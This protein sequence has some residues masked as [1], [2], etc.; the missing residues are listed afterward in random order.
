VAPFGAIGRALGRA[1]EQI[2]AVLRRAEQEG[3]AKLRL[4]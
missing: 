1:F 4:D 3:R 2:V